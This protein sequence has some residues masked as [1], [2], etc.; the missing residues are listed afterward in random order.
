MSRRIARARRL[1]SDSGLK[2]VDFRVVRLEGIANP[3]AYGLILAIDCIH[4]M[5]DPVAALRGIRTLLDPAEG[6][7]F[8]SEP[9]GSHNPLENRNSVG[10]MRATLSPFHCLTVSLAEG[11]A[12]LGTIIGEKGARDL[13]DEAGFEHFEK[14]PIENA[15]QQFYLLSGGPTVL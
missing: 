12:G 8:W 9:T 13:A 2:N 10:K 6:L 5:P 14:L 11:G 4:D 1:A 7:L 3:E 15:M